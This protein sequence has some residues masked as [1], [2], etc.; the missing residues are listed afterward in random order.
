MDTPEASNMP[1]CGVVDVVAEAFAY[2]GK[3]AALIRLFSTA[4]HLLSSTC[5][6]VARAW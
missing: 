4:G 3:A 6:A 2:D 1:T 5:R